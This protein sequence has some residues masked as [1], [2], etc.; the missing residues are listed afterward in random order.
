MT[1]N[2]R[3]R[4]Q[5]LGIGRRALGARRFHLA[6]QLVEAGEGEGQE[7]CQVGGQVGEGLFRVHVL[8]GVD[9]AVGDQAYSE[10]TLVAGITGFIVE[11]QGEVERRQLVEL[12]VRVLWIQASGVIYMYI[13][14]HWGRR[15]PRERRQPIAKTSP[16]INEEVF[17]MS[18]IIPR[19][20]HRAF[21]VACAAEG[22]QM[23]DVL[24]EAIKAFI[25]NHPPTG[26][27]KKRGRQ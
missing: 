27:A 6:G 3:D 17:R 7:R 19:G 2:Q 9:N 1:E 24:L 10:Q 15:R 23:T 8:G 16:S 25:A 12:E 14:T 21:K 13:S 11:Q 18:F 4:A 22:K 5:A 20:L 26:L